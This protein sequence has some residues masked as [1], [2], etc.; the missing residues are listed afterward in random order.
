LRS[1]V[2][3]AGKTLKGNKFLK[4]YDLNNLNDL[5]LALEELIHSVGEN[6]NA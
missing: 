1:V 6:P 3:I 5:S 4:E 2:E